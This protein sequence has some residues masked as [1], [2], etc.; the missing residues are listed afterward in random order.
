MTESPHHA[1]HPSLRSSTFYNSEM[2]YLTDRPTLEMDYV[3]MPEGWGN[4][5]MCVP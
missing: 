5:Y 1:A 2:E 3:T 4:N